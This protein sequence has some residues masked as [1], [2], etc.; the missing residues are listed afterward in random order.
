MKIQFS[1]YFVQ[2]PEAKFGITKNQVI[3]ATRT[4]DSAQQ[5]EYNGLELAFFTKQLAGTSRQRLLLVLAQQSD[6]TLLINT[7]FFLPPD[8]PRSVGSIE[9]LILL[10]EFSQRFGL[11]IRIGA[12]LSKFVLQQMIPL[13]QPVGMEVVRVLNPLNH[14]FQQQFYFRFEQQG[15]FPVVLCGL[16]FCIDT[17]EYLAWLT[18][19]DPTQDVTVAI[20]P[21]LRGHMTP[22]D[23]IKPAGTAMI[24]TRYSELGGQHSGILA[25]IE[26]DN[27][28]LE[29][30][31]GENAVYIVRNNE[32]LKAALQPV[33]E[34]HDRVTCFMMWEPTKL[35][36]TLLDADYDEAIKQQSNDDETLAE[37]DRRTM[38]LDTL[39]TMPPLTLLEWARRRAISPVKIYDSAG[40]AYE[41]VAEALTGISDEIINHSFNNAFWDIVYDGQRI[42][43]RVPKNEPDIHPTIH[44][45]LFNIAEAKNLLI[46]RE[47]L[48]GGG[49]LDFLVSAPLQT[50]RQTSVAIEF[51]HAHSN[52]LEHG[53]LEQLPSYMR[54]NGTDFGIYCILYFKGQHFQEP[55]QYDS[56]SLRVYLETLRVE[57]GLT[58]IRVIILDVSHHKPPSKV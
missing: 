15:D 25:R 45:L 33:L 40:H 26:S 48:V 2:E 14:S 13:N 10:Q 50:G 7:A 1:D 6:D 5:L 20:A 3:Q 11:T 49:M 54:A 39:P 17:D 4:P 55:A 8:L 32:T 21:Q 29:L 46:V 43:E 58:N 52:D 36:I 35:I 44:A 53:L 24:R 34:P 51:K 30:G 31:V 37:I 18:G 23:L 41:T 47:Y 16:A 57:A 56:D 38:Q 12:Q 27:Y 9:P 42:V 22:R 19:L 28:K